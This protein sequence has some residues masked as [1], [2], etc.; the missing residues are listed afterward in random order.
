MDVFRISSK[1]QTMVV[2]M[3][4]LRAYNL[5][6]EEYPLAEQYITSTDDNSWQFK[7]KVCGFEGIGRFCMGLSDEIKIVEPETLKQYIKLK[8]KNIEQNI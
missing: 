1:E 5:L 7:A 3:L 6:I 4:S 2:L 8:I